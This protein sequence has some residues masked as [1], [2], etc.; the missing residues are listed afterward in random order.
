MFFSLISIRQNINILQVFLAADSCAETVTSVW[1][2]EAICQLLKQLILLVRK[3]DVVIRCNYCSTENVVESNIQT[4][5]YIHLVPLRAHQE[6]VNT[7]LFNVYSMYIFRQ[8]NNHFQSKSLTQYPIAK[9]QKY[10][11]S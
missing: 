7:S 5:R 9:L 4:L 8:Q 2:K 10:K 6:P 3:T 1:T 11:Y